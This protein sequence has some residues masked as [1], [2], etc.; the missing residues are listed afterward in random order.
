M[1]PILTG[2]RPVSGRFWLIAS[3]LGLVFLLGGSAR[4]DI[5]TLVILRPLAVGAIA[6][7][8]VI[9]TGASIRTYSAQI[10]LFTA[11][12]ALV[13]FHL[14]PLPPSIW[15]ALPY[16]EF[17]AQID[18]AV[19]LEQQWRPLSIAPERTWNA[20]YALL[21]PMSVLLLI[22]SLDREERFAMLPVVIALGLFSGALGLIQIGGGPQSPLYYYRISNNDSAIGLLA[23]RN[24]QGVFLA[25]LFPMLAIFASL[26]ARN[27]DVRR[28]R[29]VASVALAAILIPLI[30]VTGS[31]AGLLL[32]LV[33]LASVPL[34]Y[35]RPKG[36]VVTRRKGE[37][38]L[39]ITGIIGGAVGVLLLILAGLIF[40][41]AEALDRLV[42][43]AQD[44]FRWEIW[45]PSLDFAMRYFPA[46]S[47]TGTFVEAFQ[48]DE[49]ISTLA[50]SYVN[51]VHNDWLEFLLTG[52][53][54]AAILVLLALSVWARAMF[55]A[56]R[57]KGDSRDVKFARM[58]SVI[59]AMLAVS[60]FVDYPLRTPLM[61]SLFAIV[62]IW[63]GPA[64][65][66]RKAANF[67]ASGGKI[68]DKS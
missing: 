4:H 17:I 31:R 48:R 11:L 5:A 65:I 52:G 41:R 58:A 16:R 47:G 25:T 63:M 36:D 33:G 1:S 53:A 12:L 22:C 26:E 46:G 67:E 29:T 40:S 23:N 34:L 42:G 39:P 18:A 56:W 61:A 64:H 28:I 15:Q 51:H 13:G 9:I 7:A 50:P 54:P 21:V 49:P 10:G 59:M 27:I 55:R 66:F 24:H 14:L 20:L 60:S 3:Y 45:Q 62:A 57:A 44:D 37:R 35:S 19:G 6:Y 68:A 30:L 2:N 38:K 43:G 32:G 8:L